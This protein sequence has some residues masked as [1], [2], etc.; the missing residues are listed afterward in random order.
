MMEEGTRFDEVL[1]KPPEEWPSPLSAL[2]SLARW[3]EE[4]PLDERKREAFL[5]VLEGRAESYRRRRVF[6]KRLLLVLLSVAVLSWVG[7]SAFFVATQ[8]PALSG[9]GLAYAT[10]SLALS[11]LFYLY[12]RGEPLRPAFALHF[13]LSA[14]CLAVFL[15]FLFLP[16]EEVLLS[17]STGAD[18]V[19]AVRSS[20][21]SRLPL[22]LLVLVLVHAFGYFVY[23]KW[24]RR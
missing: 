20:L 13:A 17:F 19:G 14:A 18:L 9:T 8:M 4:A 10:F 16:L 23:L 11:P 12:L 7:L 5:G 21:E 3:G 24:F 2:S 1:Q 22:F 6:S 15:P